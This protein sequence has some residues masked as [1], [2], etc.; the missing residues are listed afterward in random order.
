MKHEV[1]S[2]QTKKMLAVSLKKLM[3]KKPLSKITVS[4]IIADCGVN[5]KTFYYHFENIPALV[6]W[7]FDQEAVD[8]VKQFDLLVDAE[9]AIRFVMDYTEKNQH[10]INCVYDAVGRNEMKQFFYADFIGIL[11]SVI[12]GSERVLN[13]TADEKFKN[14]LA[15]FFTEALAG[16]LIAWLQNPQKEKKEELLENVLLVCRVAIPQVLL[17]KSQGVSPFD[18]LKRGQTGSGERSENGDHEEGN[19]VGGR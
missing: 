14:F 11:R 8:V 10:I 6:K 5:R 13:I 12:D 15:G 2:L 17:A 1:T 4:E 9:E 7:M 16:E 19:F 18:L 3:E